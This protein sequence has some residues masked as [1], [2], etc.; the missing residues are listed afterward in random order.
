GVNEERADRAFAG[1]L[2]VLVGPA[3]VIGEGLA[4]EKFGVVGGWVADDHEDDL[5]LDVDAGVV[6]P[7]VLGG[8]DAVPDED[9]G[10]VDV[11]DRGVAGVVNDVVGA[12]LEGDG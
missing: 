10:G 4:A 6:V 2:L 5:A 12:E 11:Y 3:A 1:G 9:D 8:G 7:V